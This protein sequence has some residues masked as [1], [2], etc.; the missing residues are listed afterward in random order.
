MRREERVSEV[1]TGDLNRRDAEGAEADFNKMDRMSR[2]GVFGFSEEANSPSSAPQ[3]AAR[4][5]SIC[6]SIRRCW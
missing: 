2:I 6:L 3:P 4:F 1:W 5:C